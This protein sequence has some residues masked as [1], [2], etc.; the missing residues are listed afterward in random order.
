M[1]DEPHA[2]LTQ[3]G[4]PSPLPASPDAVNLERALDAHRGK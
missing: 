4:R 3:L 2:G 1:T